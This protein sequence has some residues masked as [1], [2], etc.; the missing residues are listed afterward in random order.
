M[1]RQQL[2][3]NFELTP[4]GVANSMG[5]GGIFINVCYF[6]QKRD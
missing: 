1:E 4:N 2:L 3:K 6:K 5:G